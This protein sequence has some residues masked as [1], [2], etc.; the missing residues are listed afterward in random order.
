[1]SR[2]GTLFS[3]RQGT[4]P[5]ARAVVA[6]A[7]IAA[8]GAAPAPAAASELRAV[9]LDALRG[10]LDTSAAY[11]FTRRGLEIDVDGNTALSTGLAAR[12]AELDVEA[13]GPVTLTWAARSPAKPFT[14]F[15]PPWRHLTVPRERATVRLDLRIATGWSPAAELVLGLTG[16]GRVVVHA[17]RILPNASD[18]SEQQAAYDRALFWAPE[19][20]GH[21]TINLLTPSYWSASRGTWLSDVLAGAAVLALVATLLAAKLRGRRVRTGVALAAAALVAVGAWDLH[22]LVRFLPALN[23][24]PTPDTERRIRENYYVATEVGALAALARATLRDDERVGAMGHP[25]SWFAAQTLCFNLAPRRCAIV[26]PGEPVH[27]G[28]SGV[29]QLRDDELD[30]IVAHRAGPLPDGFVTVASL[31]PT[32]VVARRR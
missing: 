7:V 12:V 5:A 14:P 23:L 1:V 19:G 27:R 6:L 3:C 31:G 8:L 21:T 2:D 22:L 17:I 15:G 10:K 16:S 30:A 18:G 13:T 9:P 29:G 25:K 28:I 20:L 24:E 4:V 32:L 26:V 11:A